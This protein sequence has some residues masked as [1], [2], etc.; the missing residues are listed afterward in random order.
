MHLYKTQYTD[1]HFERADLLLA[2][3]AG[4]V[5]RSCASYLKVGGLLLTNNHQS[6]AAEAVNDRSFTLKGMIQFQ[7]E[8][9]PSSKKAYRKERSL[10]KK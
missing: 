3:F 4:G 6:D 1:I 9:I 5:A 2:L 7:K 10:C 8:A